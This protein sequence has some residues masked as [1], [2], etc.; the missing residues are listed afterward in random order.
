MTMRVR[1]IGLASA[2][3]FGF[4]SGLVG[5]IPLGLIVALVIR[6]VVGWLRQALEGWQSATIDAGI[7][8]KVPLD[9]IRLMNLGGT[10]AFVQRLDNSPA[11]LVFLVFVI[12]V[13]VAGILTSVTDGWQALAYNNIAAI[14]GGLEV[15]LESGEGGRTIVVRGRRET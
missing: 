10:L 14:S 1:R 3:K 6:F 15:E 5:A 4:V 11:L 7:L 12:F 13:L 8:G 2:T 9:L